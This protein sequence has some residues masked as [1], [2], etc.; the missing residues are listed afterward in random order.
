MMVC[1]CCPSLAGLGF[2]VS[3]PLLSGTGDV[4]GS[5]LLSR[6]PV[7][8]IS[9]RTTGLCWKVVLEAKIWVLGVLAAVR[10][11]GVGA[12]V[13]GSCVRVCARGHTVAVTV[14]QPG[15]EGPAWKLPTALTVTWDADG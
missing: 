5:L 2:Q 14:A 10:C 7:S 11:R 4:L 13:A 6:Q 15:C 9:P 8:P 3:L 12:S 1:R